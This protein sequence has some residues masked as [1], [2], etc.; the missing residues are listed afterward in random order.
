MQVGSL[1]LNTHRQWSGDR[2]SEIILMDL[3]TA[4]YIIVSEIKASHQVLWYVRASM[5]TR[6]R[7][8]IVE[9]FL[10]C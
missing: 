3:A 4:G 8:S 7:E 6:E 5:L 10:L 9:A 1:P 2:C